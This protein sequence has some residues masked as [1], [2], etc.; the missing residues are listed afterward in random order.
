MVLRCVPY[1]C[2]YHQLNRLDYNV[3]KSLA[4]ILALIVGQSEHHVLNSESLTDQLKD[5]T[6][7]EDER[8]NSHDVVALFTNIPIV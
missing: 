3:A 2:S 5:I 1:T 7:E 6:V 8:L 4:E